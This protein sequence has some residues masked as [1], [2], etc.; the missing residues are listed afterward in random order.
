[1][2]KRIKELRKALGLTLEKFGSNLGVTK[3]AICNIE[4]GNR[5]LTDQMFLSICREYNVNPTWL[6]T[7]T[8]TMF[9]EGLEEDEYFKAATQLSDDNDVRS[10]LMSY[11][12]QDESGKK[13][14]KNFIS[15]IIS[16]IQKNKE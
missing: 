3:T 10:V 15:N 7:G 6:E 16:E 4:A 5:N 12:K 8:G 11:W 1:M 13:A 2:N 14:I 9:I